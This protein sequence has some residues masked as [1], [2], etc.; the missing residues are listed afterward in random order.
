MGHNLV[1]AATLVAVDEERCYLGQRTSSASI[2]ARKNLF[3]ASCLGWAKLV[4]L[5]N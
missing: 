1:M 3:V 2:L 5:F 4:R